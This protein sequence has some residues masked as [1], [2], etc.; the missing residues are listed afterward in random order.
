MVE[1][2]VR[3]YTGDPENHGEV[4]FAAVLKGDQGST[5]FCEVG[6]RVKLVKLQARQQG[7][8]FAGSGEFA[9]RPG[10]AHTARRTGT[11]PENAMGQSV[12]P[13]LEQRVRAAP[14]REYL[15]EAGK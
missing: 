10:S 9:A 3:S 12:E 7:Q 13:V 6:V 4:A 1:R 2:R 5:F 8:K 14:D 11:R 15:A